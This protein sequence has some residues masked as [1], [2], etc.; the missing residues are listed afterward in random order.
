MTTGLG[1]R[2]EPAEGFVRAVWYREPAQGVCDNYR[3]TT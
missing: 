2:A 1:L 3:K